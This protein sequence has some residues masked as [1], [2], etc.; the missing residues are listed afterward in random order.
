MNE[1]SPEDK[2][3]LAEIGFRNLADEV[4]TLKADLAEARDTAAA[5]RDYEPAAVYAVVTLT[6]GL[7][8]DDS[9]VTVKGV[10][11]P[12]HRRTERGWGLAPARVVE[13]LAG[14]GWRTLEIL[15]SAASSVLVR[16][17]AT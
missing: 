15:P 11:A 2:S 9:V 1:L 7:V 10:T 13:T 4:A 5:E 14:M 12:L 6:N 8:T 3:R 17:E 16:V